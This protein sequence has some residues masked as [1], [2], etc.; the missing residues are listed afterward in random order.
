MPTILLIPAEVKYY[1]NILAL[2][3]WDDNLLFWT[4]YICF[5]VDEPLSHYLIHASSWFLSCVECVFRMSTLGVIMWRQ[6]VSLSLEFFR[7]CD[8]FVDVHEENRHTLFWSLLFI[9]LYV[10]TKCNV[11]YACDHLIIQSFH[12]IFCV[13]VFIFFWPLK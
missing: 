5:A 8:T 2:H 3:R 12:H 10:L 6:Q 7:S 1:T 4:S 11:I 9:C 13:L